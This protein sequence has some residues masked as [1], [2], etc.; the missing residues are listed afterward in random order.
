MTIKNKNIKI[1]YK[2]NACWREEQR[3]SYKNNRRHQEKNAQI[4]KIFNHIND[5]SNNLI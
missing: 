5:R 1:T 4:V 3:T 2:K